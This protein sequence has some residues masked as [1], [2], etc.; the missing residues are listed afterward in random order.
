MISERRGFRRSATLSRVSHRTKGQ[1]LALRLPPRTSRGGTLTLGTIATAV[2][3]VIPLTGLFFIGDGLRRK[4]ILLLFFAPPGLICLYYWIRD[5]VRWFLPGDTVVE[6]SQNPLRP[7]Q[8]LECFVLQ[9]GDH[10]RVRSVEAR[11][12]CRRQHHRHPVEELH[13]LSL[14]SAE[15][16][17]RSGRRAR[18]QTA[19]T[20]PADAPA[21]IESEPLK[22]RWCVEVRAVFGRNM[23]IVQE[24]PLTV[25]A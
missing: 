2:W 12:V 25:V 1:R 9:D 4:V 14:G 3:W 16:L 13:S 5:F 19:V 7:G 22:I 23:V 8:T 24:H 20:L 6:V 10:S 21:G 18:L 11:L 15:A 17:D